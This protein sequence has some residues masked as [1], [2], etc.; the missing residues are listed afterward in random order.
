MIDSIVDFHEK[1]IEKFASRN[2]RKLDFAYEK[3]Q[4]KNNVGCIF[5]ILIPT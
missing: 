5:L 2:E 3:K 4:K 1:V